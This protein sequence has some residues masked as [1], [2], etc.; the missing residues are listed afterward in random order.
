MTEKRVPT[1][2]RVEC[3]ARGSEPTGTKSVV[4][5]L[6]YYHTTK[7]MLA[8]NRTTSKYS[9]LPLPQVRLSEKNIEERPYRYSRGA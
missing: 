5:G 3:I 1:A 9:Q 4:G 8:F 6:D 7:F 2:I